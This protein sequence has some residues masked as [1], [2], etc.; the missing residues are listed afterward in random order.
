MTAPFPQYT[1]PYIFLDLRVERYCGN[2]SPAWDFKWNTR[3]AKDGER[4]ALIAN[5]IEGKRLT[6]RPTN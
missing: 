4:V 6:Y 3:K 1:V 2:G 5:G